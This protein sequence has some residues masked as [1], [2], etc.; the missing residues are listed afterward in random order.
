MSLLWLAYCFLSF[1]LIS[2]YLKKGLC[3]Y[4]HCV[5][6]VH[7]FLKFSDW[8]AFLTS[9]F[10]LS[11]E[12]FCSFVWIVLR[13]DMFYLTLKMIFPLC[14]SFAY[15]NGRCWAVYESI[16]VIT[17]CDK[18]FYFQWILRMCVHIVSRQLR[19]IFLMNYIVKPSTLLNLAI[20][21]PSH[22]VLSTLSPHRLNPPPPPH[23][24]TLITPHSN[25]RI[26][27]LA[28]TKIARN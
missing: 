3:F 5:K 22:A 16:T 12:D 26:P 21:T 27:D 24:Q 7:L 6:S 14:L 15:F 28:S 1:W 9:F 19:L 11:Q 18:P 13:S 10:H 4:V 2:L 8:I 20:W 25:A 23:T 17:I